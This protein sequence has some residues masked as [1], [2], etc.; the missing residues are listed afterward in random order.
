MCQILYF[1][2]ILFYHSSYNVLCMDFEKHTK[3]TN[4]KTH[5]VN[6][7]FLDFVCA[8]PCLVVLL[9]SNEKSFFSSCDQQASQLQNEKAVSQQSSSFVLVWL[10]PDL[11]QCS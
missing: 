6:I 3:Q 1:V 11:R 8:Q 7:Y 9:S 4:K 2:F 10:F 5:G